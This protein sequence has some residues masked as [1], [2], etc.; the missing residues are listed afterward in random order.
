[1]ELVSVLLPVYNVEKFVEESVKSILNQTYKNIEL[2]IVDDCSTDE[3]YTILQKLKQKDERIKLHRNSNNLKIAETLNV[4]FKLSSGDYICRMDGDDISHP[5]R[6]ERKVNFL[7]NFPEYSLVGCSVQSV[8]ENGDFLRNKKMISN[9]ALIQKTL[10]Y[11]SPVFHI[12]LA[13]RE[14]YEKLNGYRNIPYVEDFDF[15]LRMTSLNYKYTNIADYYGYSI[16]LR[17]GN[18]I[19]SAG[20]VQRK[21]HR[22][23]YYLYKRRNAGIEDNYSIENFNKYVHTTKN[24]FILFNKS[25]AFLQ[26]AILIKKRFSIKKLIYI[27][28]SYVLSKEQRKYLNGKTAVAFLG[29]S[30]VGD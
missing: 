7:K 19:S 9:Q 24:E 11:A 20:I 23:C 30:V 3:T 8:D 14:V 16:R 5:E 28:L 27:A 15:L 17:N 4:A 29:K 21:A 18:T 26:K 10:K 1:M 2:I 12:W 22:Y 6:I 13:R 25:N